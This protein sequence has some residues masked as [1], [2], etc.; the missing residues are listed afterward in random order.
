MA[1]SLSTASTA[2]SPSPWT[3]EQ[4]LISD[5][6]P[7][8]IA[9]IRKLILKY[10]NEIAALINE[11]PSIDD[12]CEVPATF[13][14]QRVQDNIRAAQN[15]VERRW[16]KR[17]EKIQ[18]KIARVEGKKKILEEALHLVEL[19]KSRIAAIKMRR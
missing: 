18:R 14:S 7:E 9:R 8:N 11:L 12:I 3:L 5:P 17:G 1:H 19:F 2:S 4:S 6:T 15:L 10:D 13:L 16:E